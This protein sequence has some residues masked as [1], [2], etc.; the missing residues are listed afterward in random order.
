MPLYATA[1]AGDH[2]VQFEVSVAGVCEAGLHT[3]VRAGDLAFEPAAHR[4]LI[5]WRTSPDSASGL[6]QL[7]APAQVWAVA[8]DDV[9]Q[10]GRIVP[11]QRIALL[12][13]AS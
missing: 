9:A 3:V 1:L 4:V 6:V 11:G 8:L 7:A 13:A 12:E 5:A 2:T 10:L